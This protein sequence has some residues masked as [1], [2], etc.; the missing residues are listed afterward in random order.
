[1]LVRGGYRT[2]T[3][4]SDGASERLRADM[5][6]RIREKH[7]LRAAEYVREYGIPQ[8]KNYMMIGVPGETNDDLDE[9]I[10]FT[11]KQAEVAG[12]R[13][14]VSLGIAPFVAKR[15]TPMD[16]LP[17]VGVAEAERRLERLRRG[18]MPRVEVRPTSARWAWIEYL[19][20]QSGPEAGLRAL[21]AWRAGG[22]FSAWKRAFRDKQVAN[23]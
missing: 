10:A 14:R 12:P 7:L 5:E 19:L 9:L 18:L 23:G 2:L 20:A 11:K 17:F 3:I 16:N 22:T 13:V 21:E 6:K 4:A 15:N 8:L 1:M